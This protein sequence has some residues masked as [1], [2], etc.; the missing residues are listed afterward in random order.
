MVIAP[1]QYAEFSS[2]TRTA[3]YRNRQYL[4]PTQ[5]GAYRFARFTIMD[6][7]SVRFQV[8]WKLYTLRHDSNS[9]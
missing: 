3:L 7:A 2:L 5:P 6:H 9:V 8:R 4:V 1:H